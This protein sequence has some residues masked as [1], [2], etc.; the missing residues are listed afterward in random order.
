MDLPVNDLIMATGPFKLT[1]TNNEAFVRELEGIKQEFLAT[2]AAQRGA[3]LQATPVELS[4]GL[5]YLGRQALALGLIDFLGSDSDAAAK[6]AELAGIVNYEVVEL[7]DRV[8][9]KYRQA[10]EDSDGEEAAG[11]LVRLPGEWVG[12]A[13]PLTNQRGLPPGIYL[14]YD[15]RLRREK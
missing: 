8:F 4:Q 10:Q 12:A 6:A 7:Q 1:A 5:A 13:D 2:V 15:V 14:L 3:R 11:H 9:E